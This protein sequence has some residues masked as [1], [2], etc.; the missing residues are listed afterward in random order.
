MSRRVWLV[1]AGA[2]LVALAL[3]WRATLAAPGATKSA[4]TVVLVSGRDDHGLLVAPTVALVR[5]PGSTV[6]V[7]E[8][9]DGTF[10]RALEQ[11]GDWLRVQAIANPQL[12]GW[13]NDFYLRGQAVRLDTGA[14]VGFVQARR[15]GARVLVA[16]TSVREA[17]P[18]TWVAAEQLR[19]IGAREADG[20][21]HVHSRPAAQP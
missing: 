15:D 3:A 21:R 16:V 6:V 10:A 11:R 12:D 20:H 9:P 2:A 17:A 18:P 13:I 1:V 4:A 8:V 19:E 14:Q 5:T 7:D